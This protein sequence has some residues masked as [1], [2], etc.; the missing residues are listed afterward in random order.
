MLFLIFF[1]SSCEKEEINDET[2][3]ENLQN[4]PTFKIDKDEV[5]PPGEKEGN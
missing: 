3:I 1:M 5:V 4:P 2:G